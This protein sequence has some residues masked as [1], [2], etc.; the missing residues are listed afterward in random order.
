VASQDGVARWPRE[1]R[2]GLIN[3]YNNK[4]IDSGDEEDTSCQ[5]GPDTGSRVGV[6]LYAQADELPQ[7]DK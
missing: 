3:R 4:L 6:R 2:C 5:W 7:K 1:G